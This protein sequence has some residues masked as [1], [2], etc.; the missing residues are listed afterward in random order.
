MNFSL[1]LRNTTKRKINRVK[2]TGLFL[3]LSFVTILSS[4]EKEGPEGPAGE[5]GNANV[6]SGTTTSSNWTFYDPSWV[7][8]Y[9]YS[10]I[11]QEIIE[12]GAVLVYM[13]VGNSY[14]QIPLTFYRSDSYSTS[15]E[16]STFVGGFSIFWSDSDLLEPL[17][18]GYHTFKVVVIAAS[19]TLKS[20]NI[21]FSD[22]EHVSTEFIVQ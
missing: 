17:Y 13:K 11:T 5:D 4:C 16:V 7:T 9:T 15:I 6:V 3:L 10:A 22:Y 8:T 18:P 1:S 20:G 21:D 2:K 12:S 19:E 14:N